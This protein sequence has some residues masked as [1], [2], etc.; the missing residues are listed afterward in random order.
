[1]INIETKD[2]VYKFPENFSELTIGKFQKA[3]NIQYEDDLDA[4]VKIISALADIPID[5]LEGIEF[6]EFKKLAEACQ[7]INKMV[8][9]K[10]KLELTID[11]TKYKLSME[12]SKMTTA[13]F[14]DLDGF[15]RDTDNVIDNLHLILG[16]LYRPVN[17]KGKVEKYDS[18]TIIERAK[19]FQEKM[20]VEYALS[21]LNFSLAVASSSIQITE[22]YLDQ[23]HPEKTLSNGQI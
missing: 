11:K 9:D 4:N 5:I 23:E 14:I 12:I 17:K 21:A 13:E 8:D 16:I 3:M 6:T 20:T 18:D 10:P 19:L 22:A 2:K 15:I 1:M 7:F